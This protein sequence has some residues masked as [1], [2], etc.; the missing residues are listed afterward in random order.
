VNQ[1]QWFSPSAFVDAPLNTYSP[2]RRGQNYNPG[3]ESIDVSVL[4]DTNITERVR[5]QF[6][7]DMFNLF[8]HT[9]LAP[10]GLPTTGESG[11]IGE[12]IGQFLGNPNFGPGE[13][14]NVEFGLKILF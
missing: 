3:Y 6:K 1:V 13:P 8:D 5:A 10:V 11:T 14:F 7:V 12:T 4:K 9:N 2:T